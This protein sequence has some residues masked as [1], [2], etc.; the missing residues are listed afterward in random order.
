MTETVLWGVKKEAPDY[1]E[2]VLY[3][4]KGYVNQDEILK[5]GQ[6]WA[7]KNGYDRLRLVTLN[8]STPPNFIKS[9]N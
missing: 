6:E 5:K 2:E 8:L 1:A 9:I 4:C 7:D 3:Q